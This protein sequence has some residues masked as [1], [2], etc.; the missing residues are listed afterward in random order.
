MTPFDQLLKAAFDAGGKRRVHEEE[1]TTVDGRYL[2][3]GSVPDFDEWRAS[4]PGLDDDDP[5][6]V[7]DIVEVIEG[8]PNPFEF[9]AGRRGTVQIVEDFKDDVWITFTVSPGVN[10]AA[11]ATS[12]R[13]VRP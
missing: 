13:K 4:L 12:L 6:Q 3:D 10:W 11:P 2:G 9:S 7:D 8:A 5:I 1:W